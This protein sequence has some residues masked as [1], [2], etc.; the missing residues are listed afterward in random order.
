VTQRHHERHA[1]TVDR[2]TASCPRN[3][4]VALDGFGD[5]SRE[6]IARLLL[7]TADVLA[8]GTGHPPRS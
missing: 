8:A 2:A 3:L 5:P 7:E 4:A 6:R 1:G